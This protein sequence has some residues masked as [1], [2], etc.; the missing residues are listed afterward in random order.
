VVKEKI[1]ESVASRMVLF[2]A[3]QDWQRSKAV[4]AVAILAGDRA[5]RQREMAGMFAEECRSAHVA[6]AHMLEESL[7]RMVC[8][9][10][11]RWRGAINTKRRLLW[12]EV[13]VG[14]STRPVASFCAHCP[15][16]LSSSS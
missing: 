2:Q 10:T 16:P 14:F 5:V 15:P 13:S 11:L 7:E 6:S 1:A 4:E 3:Q 9:L 12:R 8:L